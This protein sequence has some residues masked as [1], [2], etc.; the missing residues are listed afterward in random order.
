M[1]SV[2]FV[3]LPAKSE[4]PFTKASLIAVYPHTKTHSLNEKIAKDK[5]YLICSRVLYFGLVCRIL[6]YSYVF[7]SCDKGL[8]ETT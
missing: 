6:M 8:V 1:E 3:C 2:S 5:K 4:P 7:S